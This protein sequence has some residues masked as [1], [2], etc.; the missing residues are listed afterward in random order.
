MLLGRE[1]SSADI[2]LALFVAGGIAG[3]LHLIGIVGIG[4][5]FE[6][7]AVAGNLADHGAFADP[8]DAGPMGPTAANP[9]IYPLLLA[10]WFNRQ[11]GGERADGSLVTA[12]F[13]RSVR[14]SSPGNYR[15]GRVS[16]RC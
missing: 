14:G 2:S 10:C 3:L 1:D 8:F 15:V 5:G 16:G 4:R 11:Y 12:S 9:P 6:M 7:V 13:A